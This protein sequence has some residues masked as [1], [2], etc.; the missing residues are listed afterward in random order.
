MLNLAWLSHCDRIAVQHILCDYGFL[1]HRF[2]RYIALVIGHCDVPR[3]QQLLL[4]NL[5]DEVGSE[6]EPSHYEL[7][8]NLAESCNVDLEECLTDPDIEQ[9]EAWFYSIYDDENSVR[10]LAVLGP[11][12]EEISRFFLE[13]LE[14]AVIR[15]FP[16]ADMRYFEVHRPEQEQAHIQDIRRA[17]DILLAGLPESRQVDTNRLIKEYAA[18]AVAKHAAFWQMQKRHLRQV[19]STAPN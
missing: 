4:D 15:Y 10:A 9:I 14:S 5:V 7:Y 16:D 12:T 3:V 17:L 19:A 8:R 1:V 2:V 6:T 18:K 13:P 11:G